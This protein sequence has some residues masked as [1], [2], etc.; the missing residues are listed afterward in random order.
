MGDSLGPEG[1]SLMASPIYELHYADGRITRCYLDGTVT[2]A[3]AGTMIVNRA[4]VL[5]RFLQAHNVHPLVAHR[6]QQEDAPQEKRR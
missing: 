4:P 5:I 6:S 3:P 1:A 2:G